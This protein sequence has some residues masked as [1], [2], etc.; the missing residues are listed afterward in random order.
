MQSCLWAYTCCKAVP[1]RP[2]QTRSGSLAR[3]VPANRVEP[4]V[5]PAGPLLRGCRHFLQSPA[6]KVGHIFCALRHSPDRRC[7]S[8]C[9]RQNMPHRSQLRAALRRFRAASADRRFSP[10]AAL[11]A[12]D[13][14]AARPPLLSSLRQCSPRCPLIRHRPGLALGGTAFAR[15]ALRQSITFY[16]HHR[17]S[18]HAH[19]RH[20]FASRILLRQNANAAPAMTRG[21]LPTL[22]SRSSPRGFA[23]APS[24]WPSRRK[25]GGRLIRGIG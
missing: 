17:S 10:A 20:S 7:S 1:N 16:D 6:A 13:A 3:V 14:A 11:R 22:A 25:Q 15:P 23:R 9:L 12:Q 21:F 2:C 5:V 4:I 19:Q 24:A 18:T 8:S